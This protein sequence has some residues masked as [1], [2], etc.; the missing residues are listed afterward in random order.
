MSLSADDPERA[1]AE[2]LIAGEA[3]A[4]LARISASTAM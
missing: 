1:A 2:H 3:G 4:D